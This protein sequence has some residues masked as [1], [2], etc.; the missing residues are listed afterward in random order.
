MLLT[1]VH[2]DDNR[3]NMTFI[4]RRCDLSIYLDS[5]MS[6]RSHVTRLVCTCFGILRQIRIESDDLFHGPH[7]RRSSPASSCQNW[8]T[9]TSLSPACPAATW[10]VCSPSSMLPHACQLARS[11][12]TT[13]LLSLPTS[14]GCAYLST[15]STSCAYWFTTAFRGPHWATCRTPS[16]GRKC[17][18]TAS[19]ALHV[20]GRSHHAGDATYNNGRQRLHSTARLKQSVR[21]DPLQLISGCLQTFTENSL[22]YPEFLLIIVFITFSLRVVNTVKCP[23]SNF[24]LFTTF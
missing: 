20:I 6:M 1:A 3:Y 2:I 17:G 19:P 12:T 5:N 10:T 7:R 23:W 16:A 15:S 24:L 13:S 8:T 14:T 11:T 18:I 4:E 22:L 9:A 21:R